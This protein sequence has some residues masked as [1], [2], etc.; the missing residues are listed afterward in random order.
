MHRQGSVPTA[1]LEADPFSYTPMKDAGF[2]P[3]Q[4]EELDA[5]F[6]VVT[7]ALKR[8]SDIVSD[9]DERLDNIEEYLKNLPTR[10]EWQIMYDNMMHEFRHHE[11][12]MAALDSR[13]FRC[14]EKLGIG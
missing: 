7:K 5:R 13:M 11:T 14:E 1:I 9:H 10:N 3:R 12:E 2:T 4:K 6:S 8:L